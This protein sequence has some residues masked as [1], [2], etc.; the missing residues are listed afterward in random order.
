MRRHR[1]RHGGAGTAA[2]T[3]VA[4]HR[5]DVSLAWN[6]RPTCERDASGG[7]GTISRMQKPTLRTYEGF[8]AV[9]NAVTLPASSSVRLQRNG[10][11]KVQCARIAGVEVPNKKRIETSLTY[12]NARRDDRVNKGRGTSEGDAIVVRVSAFVPCYL[13]LMAGYERTAETVGIARF[14]IRMRSC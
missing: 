7:A 11:V 8:R 4:L 6:E 3:D 5:A 1:T 12:V 9:N 2:E 10:P 13:S 14:E